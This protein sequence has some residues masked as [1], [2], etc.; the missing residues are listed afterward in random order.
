MRIDLHCHSYYS[1]GTDSPIE[2]VEQARQNNVE[3]LALTDHD[4]IDGVAELQH[5]ADSI[6]MKSISGIEFSTRW[7][8][9]E[10]HVLGLDVDTTHS[11]LLSAIQYQHESR[12]TRAK[13]IGNKLEEL[14]LHQAYEKACAVA[15]HTHIARPHFAQ[16]LIQ[17]GWVKDIAKAFT[18]Y[19][20]RGKVAFVATPW[21]SLEDVVDAIVSSGGVAVVAHPH[22]YSMTKHKLNNLLCDFKAAGGLAMEVVS[23]NITT[24]Q[25]N[26]LATMCRSLGLMASTGSDFHGNSKSNIALGCQMALPDDLPVLWEHISF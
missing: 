26:A 9:E 12:V 8:K 22:K 14:G 5:A 3:L 21:L 17:E 20:K 19:L 7:K 1:D 18:R 4:S 2:L 25:I 23:G 16:V 11:N 13:L 15:G 10:L 24:Q 6:G